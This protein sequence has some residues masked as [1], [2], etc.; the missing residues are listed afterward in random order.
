MW[1]N[2]IFA[3]LFGGSFAI[4]GIA[5][6]LTPPEFTLARACFIFAALVILGRICWW[7]SA[8]LKP[9]NTMFFISLII[10][11]FVIG[12]VLAGGLGN[13]RDEISG[14]VLIN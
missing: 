6:T 10:S 3:V 8:E 5:M 7:I 11:F 2:I 12:S 14:T 1:E 9:V 4:G 13:I